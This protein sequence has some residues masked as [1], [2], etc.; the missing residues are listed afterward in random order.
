MSL[1]SALSV[2][3]ACLL[4]LAGCAKETPPPVDYSGPVADWPAYGAAPGGGHY[5]PAT[6]ITK[7]NVRHLQKAWEYRSGDFRAAGSAQI[8]LVPGHK[9]PVPATSW[10]MTPL[11][12]DGTLYGC[13]SFNRLF[14]LDPA[15]GNEKWSFNPGVDGSKEVLANCRGVS[16]WATATPTGAHCDSRI[17]EGTLDGRLVAVDAKDGKPCEGFGKIGRAHV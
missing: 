1:R 9:Q 7:D 16:H 3:A 8:E 10:Q 5:S 14:A 2:S 15:T 11:L 4:L 12:V 17:I 13:S 6:Q